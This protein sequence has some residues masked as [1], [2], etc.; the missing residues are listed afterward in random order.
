MDGQINWGGVFSPNMWCSPT[1]LLLPQ[2]PTV[3]APILNLTLLCVTFFCG[4]TFGYN[5]PDLKHPAWPLNLRFPCLNSLESRKQGPGSCCWSS[6]FHGERIGIT[7]K[8]MFEIQRG[9]HEPAFLHLLVH[10]YSCWIK[11]NDPSST[12]KWAEAF[13]AQWTSA[14]KYACLPFSSLQNFSS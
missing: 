13:E 3:Y 5:V 4:Y 2:T 9:N 11:W 1:I 10:L 12:N 7:S 8:Y 6:L 14:K